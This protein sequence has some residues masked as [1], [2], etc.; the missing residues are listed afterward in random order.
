MTPKEIYNEM[1]KVWQNERELVNIIFGNNKRTNSFTMFFINTVF[2]P[3]SRFRPESK[4]GEEKYLHDHTAILA[5][6]AEANHALKYII[7]GQ[8]TD[9]DKDIDQHK[10]INSKSVM[11]SKTNEVKQS[12]FYGH[13]LKRLKGKSEFVNK[14]LE[15][16]D[17]INCFIDSSKSSRMADRDYKGVRQIL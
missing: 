2:V 12:Q 15:L 7:A 9:K 8:F 10:F 13:A 17:S 3:P 6:I 5:R 4:M 14:W 1:R 11:H 16:Q